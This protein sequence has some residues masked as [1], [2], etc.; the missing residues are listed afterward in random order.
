MIIRMG[1]IYAYISFINYT[2]Y[3]QYT[4]VISNQNLKQSH[5]SMSGNQS[6]QHHQDEVCSFGDY[7]GIKYIHV[8]SIV[9]VTIVNDISDKQNSSVHRYKHPVGNCHV[10][11]SKENSSLCQ[12]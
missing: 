2:Q 1:S 12:L 11:N 4:L 6:S 3:L 5:S 8:C 7:S 10:E 9:N